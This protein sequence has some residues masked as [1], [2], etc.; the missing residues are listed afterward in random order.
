MTNKIIKF[1]QT[2]IKNEIDGLSENLQ[3]WV[4]IHL[5]EPRL[6]DLIIDLDTNRKGQ[7][8]LITDNIGVNDSSY[9]VVFDEKTNEF[10]LECTLD[11]KR[12]WFM[13]IYGNFSDTIK[14][15]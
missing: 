14:S 2:S 7:F 8:W 3:D 10:G 1:I 5:I 15:M 6:I 11:D 13:G 12:E 9:R 4:N